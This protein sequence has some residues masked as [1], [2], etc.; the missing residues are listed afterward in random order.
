MIVLAREFG[1]R[2]PFLRAE[3]PGVF[4]AVLPVRLFLRFRPAGF[5]YYPEILNSKKPVEPP[6]P[7]YR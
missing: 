4:E 2:G 3:R 7:A 5:P 6:E 1:K